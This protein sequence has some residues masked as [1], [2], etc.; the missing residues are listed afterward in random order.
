MA[1]PF[2]NDFEVN[3]TDTDT[4]APNTFKVLGHLA[5]LEGV[6]CIG[7]ANAFNEKWMHRHA[8]NTSNW[9]LD[10][11]GERAQYLADRCAQN[12]HVTSRHLEDKAI[13]GGVWR[14]QCTNSQQANVLADQI[15][16]TI[17]T[18]EI[19]AQFEIYPIAATTIR[20]KDAARAEG[21][22][23]LT[24]EQIASVVVPRRKTCK[25]TAEMDPE[26]NVVGMHLSFLS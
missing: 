20:A 14:V 21:A 25:V 19:K 18:E 11:W 12:A 6:V 5:A 9:A 15:K 3:G 23:F 7:D 17:N 8:G 22:G 1:D 2:I 16:R 13:E 10:I 4:P 24:A 26:G